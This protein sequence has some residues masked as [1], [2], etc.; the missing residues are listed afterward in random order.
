MLLYFSFV[1]IKISYLGATR[2]LDVE[3]LFTSAVVCPVGKQL[4]VADV[5]SMYTVLCLLYTVRRD[6]LVVNPFRRS[7]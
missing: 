7:F 1:D 2:E 5:S 3:L 6:R 4:G